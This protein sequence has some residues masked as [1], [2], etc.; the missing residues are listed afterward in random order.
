MGDCF[1]SFRRDPF[2]A[3]R[4]EADAGHRSEIGR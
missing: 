4:P 3:R 1:V 2:R